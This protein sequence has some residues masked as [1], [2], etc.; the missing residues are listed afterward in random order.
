MKL[1]I[2]GS[3]G[4]PSNQHQPVGARVDDVG[5]GRPLWSPAG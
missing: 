5:L 4:V 3:E 1:L 2:T